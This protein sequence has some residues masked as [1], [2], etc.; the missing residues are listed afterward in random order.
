MQNLLQIVQA[1]CIRSGIPAPASVVGTFDQQIMQIQGLLEEVGQFLQSEYKW[2]FT[3]RDATFISVAAENQGALTTLFGVDAPSY[4]RIVPATFWDR[5][6][7]RPIFGGV[8]DKTWQILKAFIPGGPLYQYRIIQGNLLLNPAPPAG[9][10][11]ALTWVSKN[12]VSLAGGGTGYTFANDA[13]TPLFQDHLMLIGLRAVW[14]RE[15]GLPYADLFDDFQRR[16]ENLAGRSTAPA[17][18]S[19]D[20]PGQQLVPGIFVP[21]GNW[22][23]R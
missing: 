3:T 15:K 19:L 14:M 16:A 7:R 22:N 13:D 2:E 11:M 8:S 10:T 9:D 21:A 17:A 1:H 4:D 6:L 18:L 20:N 23:V 5:T 12:W